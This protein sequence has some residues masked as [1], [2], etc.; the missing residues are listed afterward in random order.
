[1]DED[2][3][4]HFGLEDVPGMKD[5]VNDVFEMERRRESYKKYEKLRV[6]MIL[7][8]HSNDKNA[9]LAYLEEFSMLVYDSYLFV[10]TCESAMKSRV[11]TET[12]RTRIRA[13][14]SEFFIRA[15]QKEDIMN[16]QMRR[17]ENDAILKK[18]IDDEEHKHRNDQKPNNA[19]YRQWV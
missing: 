5:A 18:I 16:L 7:Y 2:E 11:F 4:R 10:S 12:D 13:V 17:E 14:I 8:L 9:F 1:M 15:R 19:A 3:D 6:Q